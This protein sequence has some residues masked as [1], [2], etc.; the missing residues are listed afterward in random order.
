MEISVSYYSLHGKTGDT[1]EFIN[2]C[3]ENGVKY[4]ELLD[5]H[6]SEEEDIHKVNQVLENLNMKVSS[7]SIR[8]DFVKVTEEERREEVELMKKKIDKALLLNTKLLRVFSGD[9]KEGILFETAK[10]WIIDCF[11]EVVKYAEEKGI[12]LAIENHGL[13]VGRSSQVKELIE[14]VGSVALRSTTDTGNFLIANEEPVS[15]VKNLEEYISF[16]HF[17]D[18]KE[19]DTGFT[20]LD[21]RKYKGTALG[22]GEVPLKEIVK[23]LSSIDYKGLLS[24]EL[25][26]GEHE[27][28]LDNIDS[29]RYAKTLL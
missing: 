7:Y 21:G 24:I 18:L 27:V 3:H 12:T 29:I 23:F 14:A 17:K 9:R 10:Q 6:L 26:E 2:F 15:A 20:S 8:N 1:F 16:V 13:F 22:Q 11:K 25:E 4:V 19:S 5:Y 28:L